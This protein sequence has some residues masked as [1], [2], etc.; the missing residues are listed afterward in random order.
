MTPQLPPEWHWTGAAMAAGILYWAFLRLPWH[1][2]RG[3]AE[4]QRIFAIV[5]AILIG[6]RGFSTQAVMDVNLHFLGA[7]IATLMFGARFALLALAVVSAAWALMGRVWL[8]WGWDFLANDALPVA[9]T[10][11]IGALV[12]HRLPSHVFVYIFGNAFFAAALSMAASVLTKATISAWLGGDAAPY[13]IAAIPISFGEAFFT[14][15]TMALIVTYR[16]QWCASF[17]DA[18]YLGRGK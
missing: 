7:A 10:A 3:D 5:I 14:G 9:V 13:L 11:G 15:G 4:A 6:L 1:K 18:R 16:P 17:D 2:V 12:N 8:G